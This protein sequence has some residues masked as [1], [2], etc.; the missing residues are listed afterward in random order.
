MRTS[1]RTEPSNC[2]FFRLVEF[3][4]KEEEYDAMKL[5]VRIEHFSNR[6]GVHEELKRLASILTVMHPTLVQS[7]TSGFILSFVKK[8]AENCRCDKFDG[9][10]K[11]AC[12]VCEAMW[13][14]VEDK[15]DLDWR[16]DLKLPMI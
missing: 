3:L 10:D 8:M 1:S 9:R 12:V 15:Y 6:F 13:N 4:A 2:K 16:D 14:A 5:A 11:A 7:F